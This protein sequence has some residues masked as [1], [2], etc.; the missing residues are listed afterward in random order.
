MIGFRKSALL[1]LAALL[2]LA[3]GAAP[4]RACEGAK[5]H[6]ERGVKVA[7]CGECG[8]GEAAEKGAKCEG[9]ACEH[10]K[11]HCE[12]GKCADCPKCAAKDCGDCKAKRESCGGER[13]AE[14]GER[15]T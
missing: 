9:A 15:K 7:H 13:K 2:L 14:D 1:S 6:A 4:A 5:A 3:W 10:C 12:D 8:K 11:A